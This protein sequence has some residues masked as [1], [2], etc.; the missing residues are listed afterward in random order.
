MELF[1]QIYPSRSRVTFSEAFIYQFFTT[2]RGYA[3]PLLLF[4][5]KTGGCHL[6]YSI[7]LWHSRHAR[8]FYFPD[9]SYGT[10]IP[11]FLARAMSSF[12]RLSSLPKRWTSFFSHSSSSFADFNSVAN[13]KKADAL[14]KPAVVFDEDGV[15]CVSWVY[16]P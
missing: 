8:P 5:H 9:K 12:F 2:L 4:E 7:L 16:R 1:E 10:V 14:P 13:R 15:F 3:R 6:G 11:P